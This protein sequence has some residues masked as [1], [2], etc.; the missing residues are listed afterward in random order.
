MKRAWT[1]AGKLGANGKLDEG[2]GGGKSYK[3]KKEDL[4][5]KVKN[6]L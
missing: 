4:E 2:E 6:D 3:S 5:K 1:A